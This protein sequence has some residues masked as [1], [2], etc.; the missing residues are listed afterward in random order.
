MDAAFLIVVGA[1]LCLLSVLIGVRLAAGGASARQISAPV[2]ELWVVFALWTAVLAATR[3]AV[4]APA[5]ATVWEEMRHLGNRLADLKAGVRYG[6]GIG[7]A[8][9]LAACVH[10]VVTLGRAMGGHPF[11]VRGGEE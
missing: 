6:L 9:G 4:G 5:G 8:V 2:I 3:S 11:Q 7:L 1:A 10:L